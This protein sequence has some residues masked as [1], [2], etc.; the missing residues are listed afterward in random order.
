MPGSVA[1]DPQLVHFISGGT[2]SRRVEDAV[3]RVEHVN[4]ISKPVV[5]SPVL[6]KTR[7][8]P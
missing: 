3:K 1:P 4:P 6:N 5:A 8:P 2:D 7:N